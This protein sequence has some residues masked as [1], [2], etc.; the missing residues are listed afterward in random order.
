MFDLLKTLCCKATTVLFVAAIS[1]GSSFSV[2]ILRIPTRSLFVSLPLK[3]APAT[4]LFCTVFPSRSSAMPIRLEKKG[5]AARG[6]PKSAKRSL[7]SIK[8]CL[9]S[10]NPTSKRERFVIALSTSTWEKSGLIVTSRLRLL[11]IVKRASPPT[12][13]SVKLSSSSLSCPAMAFT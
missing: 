5:F 3:R 4:I 1:I 12:F 13:I 11:P 6:S 7:F 9:R 8:N 2:C 10:G